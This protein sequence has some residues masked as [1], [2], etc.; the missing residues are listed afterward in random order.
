MDGSFSSFPTSSVVHLRSRTVTS[1][2]AQLTPRLA[3]KPKAKADKGGPAGGLSQGALAESATDAAVAAGPWRSP[4]SA[5]P[6]L[7]AARLLGFQAS[8]G[9][10][11][12]DGTG[13]GKA[14]V[15]L[16]RR[17]VL[18]ETWPLVLRKCLLPGGWLQPL[19]GFQG[20]SEAD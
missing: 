11:D 9:Q 8:L 7:A 1:T 12:G 13:R 3:E 4:T 16:G 10:R 2:C 18:P 6:S 15:L 19:V 17:S 14:S 20:S 5:V